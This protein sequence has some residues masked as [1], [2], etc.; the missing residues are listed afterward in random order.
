MPKSLEIV[1][2]LI[3]QEG[4]P[5]P[6]LVDGEHKN[7]KGSVRKDPGYHSGLFKVA[8]QLEIGRHFTDNTA[9]A[10]DSGNSSDADVWRCY[11]CGLKRCRRFGLL[12]L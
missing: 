2:G 5:C 10:T 11:R 7:Q 3:G 9:Y 6:A 8:K 4:D 12:P 1:Q